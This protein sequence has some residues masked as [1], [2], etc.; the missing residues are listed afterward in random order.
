MG[1][2][3]SSEQPLPLNVDGQTVCSDCLIQLKCLANKDN[4]IIGLTCPQCKTLWPLMLPNTP[5]V[6]SQ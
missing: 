6:G 2:K 3:L 4:I 5:L 1:R